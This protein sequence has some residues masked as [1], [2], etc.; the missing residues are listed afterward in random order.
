MVEG[1]ISMEAGSIWLTVYFEDPFW[2]GVFEQVENGR[3]AVAKVVFGGEPRDADVFALILE[4]YNVLKFSPTVD[5]ERKTISQNPKRRQR[6]ARR[7]LSRAG[8]GTKSQQALQYQREERKDQRKTA[9]KQ[10]KEAE[11]QRHFEEKQ[12]KRKE[13]HK[14]R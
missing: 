9:R 12:Q 10:E 5:A 3:L 14:G 6:E 7:Q 11:K 1:G 13:K 4:R 2:V 8:I